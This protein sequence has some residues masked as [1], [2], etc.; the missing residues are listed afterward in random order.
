MVTCLPS[1]G[2]VT[3]DRWGTYGGFV[4][5]ESVHNQ[6]IQ[7]SFVKCDTTWRNF[8]PQFRMG[9]MFMSFLSAPSIIPLSGYLEHNICKVET[10]WSDI[11]EFFF[12][13]GGEKENNVSIKPLC[14]LITYIA[15][16]RLLCF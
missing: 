16:N 13:F 14:S 9:V 3:L 5:S 15:L 2:V 1:T 8:R 10:I 4:V 11:L 12:L 7:D 6:D